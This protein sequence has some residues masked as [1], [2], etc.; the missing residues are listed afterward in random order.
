VRSLK[1]DSDYPAFQVI[2]HSPSFL[3]RY[4][5]PQMTSKVPFGS[6]LYLCRP[7]CE[8]D[9][10]RLEE[11]SR[12]WDKGWGHVF[13]KDWFSQPAVH[14][15]TETSRE[16][17]RSTH[18]RDDRLN[19]ASKNWSN[20][21]LVDGKGKIW[22]R[23][24]SAGCT[25]VFRRCH[26]RADFPQALFP[27]SWSELMVPN[28]AVPV[29][30]LYAIT[31]ILADLTEPDFTLPLIQ[32]IQ[33]SIL[34]TTLFTIEVLFT[35]SMYNAS[36]HQGR[37]L[38]GEFGYHPVRT[39]PSPEREWKGSVGFQVWVWERDHQRPHMHPQVQSD[40]P[41]ASVPTL[42]RFYQGLTGTERNLIVHCLRGVERG[43]LP[44]KLFCSIQRVDQLIREIRD[45][46]MLCREALSEAG[47]VLEESK[48]A[49]L[50]VLLLPMAERLRR[51]AWF[52]G[53]EVMSFPINTRL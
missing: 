2:F 26:Q 18:G 30:G 20:F 17:W 48:K 46:L 4:T 15:I 36:E 38:A 53:E 40:L 11:N 29:T 32:V 8:E 19:P 39:V 12:Q 7:H 37:L 41:M 45:K 33:A 31:E 13:S 25:E 3:H 52:Y 28:P 49:R 5:L 34:I 51:L 43:I 44:D 50:N 35:Q 42:A 10:R 14:S 21:L 47:M 24:F 6:H 27:V 16:F 9:Y 23:H 22:G 1:T